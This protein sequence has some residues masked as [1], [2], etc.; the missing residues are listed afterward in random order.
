M[1]HL[2]DNGLVEACQVTPLNFKD[3]IAWSCEF[4]LLCHISHHAHLFE[5]TN[6][7]ATLQNGWFKPDVLPSLLFF[8]FTLEKVY[9]SA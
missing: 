6:G 9:I 7:D 3:E 2:S 4:K 5:T 8:H 1:L